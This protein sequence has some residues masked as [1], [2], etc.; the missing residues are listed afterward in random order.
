M[1]EREGR[2]RKEEMEEKM[3]ARRAMIEGKNWNGML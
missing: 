3:K 1:I 2:K